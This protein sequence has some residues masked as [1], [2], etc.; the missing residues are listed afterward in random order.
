MPFLTSLATGLA[1]V[2]GDQTSELRRRQLMKEQDARAG[3][4]QQ[5]TFDQQARLAQMRNEAKNAFAAASP[6]LQA[7]IDKGD[8]QSA[9]QIAMRDPNDAKHWKNYFNTIG[10]KHYE[11]TVKQESHPAALKRE[12]EKA[13]VRQGVQT[14]GYKTR[15][16]IFKATGGGASGKKSGPAETGEKAKKKERAAIKE[17]LSILRSQNR[18]LLADNAGMS[19]TVEVENPK[20]KD[21]WYSREPKTI[22]APNVRLEDNKALIK[23]N[24]EEI[25]SLEEKLLGKPSVASTIGE[26]SLTAAPSLALQV[27][28]APPM[29]RP[30]P[31]KPSTGQ[32]PQLMPAQPKVSKNAA[33]ILKMI[34]EFK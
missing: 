25:R 31:A 4:K 3:A 16:E 10:R 20:Y 24:N 2:V 33:A 1:G 11:E 32:K 28:Q 5:A 15:R 22:P 7:A 9:A 8:F 21:A 23:K 6:A 26:A 34:Q 27:G 18:N 12:E 17:R 13:A 19:S 14:E 30:A 29:E